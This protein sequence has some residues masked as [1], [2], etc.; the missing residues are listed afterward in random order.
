MIGKTFNFGVV[1][2]EE[3]GEFKTNR[4]SDTRYFSPTVSFHPDTLLSQ[5]NQLNSE[6]Y[7]EKILLH[8]T[9]LVSHLSLK[10][11]DYQLPFINFLFPPLLLQ[12][13]KAAVITLMEHAHHLG[14]FF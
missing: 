8:P 5:I 14:P 10:I 12:Q 2:E 4:K 11:M 3:A 6:R 9:E 7:Q 13:A 1:G